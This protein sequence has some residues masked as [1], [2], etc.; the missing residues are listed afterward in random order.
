MYFIFDINSLYGFENVAQGT[1]NIENDDNFIAIDANFEENILY[2]DITRF[3]KDKNNKY[4]KKNGTIEQYYYSNDTLSS[5]LT[6]IGFE[7]ENIIE[8]N[9]H[10]QEEFDKYIFVCKKGIK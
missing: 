9:L 1:L 5:I 3:Q 10:T 8:F 2:T 7:V 4:T 6:R